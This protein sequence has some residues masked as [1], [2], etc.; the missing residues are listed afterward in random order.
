MVAVV[1]GFS[2]L[3]H[4]VT[5]WQK[6]PEFHGLEGNFTEGPRFDNDRF[7]F[8]YI[9]HPIDGSEFYLTARNRN[10]S[11][12][13]SLSYA[14]A[15]STSFELFIESAYERASWQ[16]L[17]ITP[18]SGAVLGELR[19]QA[20]KSLEHPSTGR[21]IGTANKILY[22]FIDPFDAVYKL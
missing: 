22:V 2:L 5:G 7:Y 6:D 21:P 1:A 12:W 16:D 9:A 11:W 18:V 8:N 20:K 13:Q 14:A 15:V 3:P 19:W 4:D 10:L 17:F